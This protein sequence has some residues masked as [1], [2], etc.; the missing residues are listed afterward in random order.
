MSEIWIPLRHRGLF[1]NLTDRI[2]RGVRIE[3]GHDDFVIVS[4]G[5]SFVPPTMV[6]VEAQVGSES[7]SLQVY[8]P[9]WENPHQAIAILVDAINAME[10]GDRDAPQRNG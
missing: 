1:S 6:T 2:E 10:Q 5:Y 3:S 7:L 9:V 4:T 8:N